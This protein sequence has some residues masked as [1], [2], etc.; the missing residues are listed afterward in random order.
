VKSEF[1]SQRT[2]GKSPIVVSVTSGKGGVGKTLTTVNL[3]IAA[4]RLGYEVLIFDGDLGLANV[5]VVLGLQARYNINDVLEGHRTINEII[6]NGPMGIKIIPSGSGINRLTQLT[7][8]QRIQILDQLESLEESF[9]LIL[10]D[11]GAGI[12]DNVLHLNAS[13]D[14]NLVVT[15]PEPHA[16]TDAYAIIK[17]LSENYG[18][19]KFS[20]V[21]NMA[22]S[23]KEGLK[24]YERIAEVAKRFLEVD[25]AFAGHV[26]NDPQ[27]QKS[28]ALRKGLN[29]NLTYTIAGQAWN[30][31]ARDLL[32]G[33][34]PA[35]STREQQDV[36]R[37]LFWIQQNQ[38]IA[39]SGF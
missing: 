9:D 30:Q 35:R 28:L 17:V 27:I 20:L 39:T 37:E 6:L 19:K 21:V 2:Q 11:T 26:P 4:R 16:M 22:S 23:V 5:D 24:I 34:A 1:K 12:S 14:R 8:G 15:T 7:Y 31:V 10:I 38:A 33:S 32:E 25:I 29:E 13:A 3:A 18:K 36:W